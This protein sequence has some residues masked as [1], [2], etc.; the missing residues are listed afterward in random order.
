M[1]R[2]LMFAMLLLLWLFGGTVFKKFVFFVAT[3]PTCQLHK[4]VLLISFH[5][6]PAQF[7]TVQ[8]A[9]SVWVVDANMHKI[10]NGHRV[11][12]QVSHNVS[13]K[14]YSITIVDCGSL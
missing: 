8:I 6:D 7:A 4:T 13:P 11:K 3:P 10:P 5:H 14:A 9:I 12:V 2:V 1:L